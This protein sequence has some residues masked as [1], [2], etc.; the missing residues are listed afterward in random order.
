MISLIGNACLS[1]MSGSAPK[2]IQ[3]FKPV[4]FGFLIVL[5]LFFACAHRQEKSAEHTQSTESQDEEEIP[6][7]FEEVIKDSVVMS[8][9]KQ[10]LFLLK[11][12]QYDRLSEYFHPTRGVRFSPYGYIDT[13]NHVKFTADIF[14]QQLEESSRVKWGSYDGT[15]EDILLTTAEYLE[16]FV[17]DVDFLNAEQT[18]VNEMI[19]EGN[20][21][22]NL[23]T[24]YQGFVYS[25]SYFSGFMEKYEGMDWR[26]LRL[27]FQSHQGYPFLVAAVHDQWTI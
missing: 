11:N 7:S 8:L 2:K 12:K 22:N 9:T 19:G 13:L 27:V 24:V 14:L 10:V 6:N 16:K 15:G 5:M 25:E 21:L 4:K 1:A 20:S 17:Y 23:E 3:I 18:V 26:S